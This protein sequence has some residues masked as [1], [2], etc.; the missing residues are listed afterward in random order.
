MSRLA[1]RLEATE[2][3]EMKSKMAKDVHPT[4]ATEDRAETSLEK[5]QKSISRHEEEAKREAKELNKENVAKGANPCLDKVI[6]KRTKNAAVTSVATRAIA[7]ALDGNVCVD[8][9]RGHN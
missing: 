1:D 6:T 2:K 7:P 9:E 5:L 4:R 8:F 3:E